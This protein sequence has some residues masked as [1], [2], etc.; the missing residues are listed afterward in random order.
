[1]EAVDSTGANVGALSGHDQP[2][3]AA[4][5]V[6]KTFVS[7]GLRDW[8]RHRP[9]R[10][11]A[12][13]KDVSFQVAPGQVTA[14]LGPNG[15]GKTTLINI[16]C[17][18]VRA[19][20]GRV[21]IAGLPVP[22]RAREARQRIGLV[23][24]NERSFLWRLTGRQN[25]AFFG[26]LQ[27]LPRDVL[28]V[29]QRRLL[30]EFGLEQHADRLFRTYSSGMKKRLSLAR[31]LLHDP[32]V[33]LMDEATSG[34]DATASEAL[35]KLI[36]ERVTA[37]GK[38]V[39]W[40]THRVEEVLALCDCVLVLVE[41][42]IRFHGSIREFRERCNPRSGFVVE[43]NRLDGSDAR[44]AEFVGSVAG[45]AETDEACTRLVLP[46]VETPEQLSHVLQRLLELGLRIRQV[47]RCPISLREVFA[48]LA[49]SQPEIGGALARGPSRDA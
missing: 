31:A 36:R 20:R 23:T 14:L 5:G 8:L 22:E 48:H 30:A 13:L 33:L 29:R 4:E 3:I 27:D 44:V 21:S 9:A 17:D 18:L 1:M 32:Q 28:R 35:L 40:A 19:A 42:D 16:I 34:L 49:P 7:R 26:A 39:L 37:L 45:T 2:L 15:A 41:G 11:V 12:A 24:T 38:C 47:E 25:L 43:T 6:S 10:R 46:A